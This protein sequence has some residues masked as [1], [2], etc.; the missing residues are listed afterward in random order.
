MTQSGMAKLAQANQISQ[1]TLS[2]IRQGKIEALHC[3]YML[4]C[5]SERSEES[6][7]Q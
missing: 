1:N 6:R 2:L 7:L 3:N 4:V 5:H